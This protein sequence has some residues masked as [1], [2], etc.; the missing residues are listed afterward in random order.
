MVRQNINGEESV[1][2]ASLL[3]GLQEAE[4]ERKTREGTGDPLN[5][6]E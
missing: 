1:V 2:E 6:H 4:R 3:H 5:L